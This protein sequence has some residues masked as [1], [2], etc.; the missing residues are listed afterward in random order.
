MPLKYSLV[1][2]NLADAKTRYDRA[3]AYAHLKNLDGQMSD[4]LNDRSMNEDQKYAQYNRILQM[5]GNLTKVDEFNRHQR[6]QEQRRDDT[7]DDAVFTPGFS[8]IARRLSLS[9]AEDTPIAGRSASRF[10]TPSTSTPGPTTPKSSK[11]SDS[12]ILE[13]HRKVRDMQP[14]DDRKEQVS[15]M[16]DVLEPYLG[17]DINRS[18]KSLRIGTKNFS[19]AKLE[20][21]LDVLAREDTYPTRPAKELANFLIKRGYQG[22]PNIDIKKLYEPLTRR[23]RQE[24]VKTKSQGGTGLV[25]RWKCL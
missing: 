11:W 3:A 2:V 8:P 15:E 4:I 17:R 6:G 10:E 14:T 23:T 7:R 19:N 21:A 22:I 18:G 13:L 9:G 24:T 25:K 5:H 12:T 20:N 1:P 16:M